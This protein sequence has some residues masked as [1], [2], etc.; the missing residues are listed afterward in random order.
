MLVGSCLPALWD[1][2]LQHPKHKHPQFRD[3]EILIEKKKSEAKKLLIALED[4]KKIF[5]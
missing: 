2:K 1:F 5:H 4:E 3:L